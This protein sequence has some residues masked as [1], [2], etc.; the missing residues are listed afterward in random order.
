VSEDLLRAW[1]ELGVPPGSMDEVRALPGP[2]AIIAEHLFQLVQRLCAT[3]PAQESRGD[4]HQ[5]VAGA[6]RDGSALGVVQG[7]EYR[8]DVHRAIVRA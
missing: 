6:G 5:P 1:V 4:S 7:I 2:P 3:G 8:G